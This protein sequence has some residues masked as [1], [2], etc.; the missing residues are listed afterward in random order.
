[1]PVFEHDGIRFNYRESG[2]GLP[3]IFQHGLTA[4]LT[5]TFGVFTPPAGVRMI[6][7]D[8]RN[9][10]LT[11][12]YTNERVGLAAFA[13]DLAGLMDH[14]NIERAVIGGISMG[15]AIALNFA[16]RNASRVMALVISRPAWLEGPLP[17]NVEI[18]RTIAGLIVQHG[19]QAAQ[20]IFKESSLYGSTLRD[21]PAVAGTLLN[22]FNLPD[23]EHRI[24]LLDRIPRDQP[25]A[26]LGELAALRVPTLVLAN[27]QDP[28]HPYEVGEAIA[29]AIP[30]AEF[31]ELTAKSVS[32]DQHNADVQRCIEGFLKR[33]FLN[34]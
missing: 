12:P 34:G 18:Y 27:R 31:M 4:D 6:G 15:S 11:R 19:P 30:G 17:Q 26:S 9:H 5:Q 20:A 16:L 3:F 14:L 33:R 25:Y 29:A 23:I 24:V 1:M 13:D 10:G 2:N 28:V 8:C 7:F 21:S 22:A 32:P